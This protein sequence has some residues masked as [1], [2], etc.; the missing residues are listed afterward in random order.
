M[1]ERDK[2]LSKH[3]NEVRDVVAPSNV[4]DAALISREVGLLVDPPD[5]IQFNVA[6]GA[7]RIKMYIDRKQVEGFLNDFCSTDDTRSSLMKKWG[8]NPQLAHHIINSHPKAIASEVRRRVVKEQT[9]RERQQAWHASRN[10]REQQVI[11]LLTEIRDILRD[12][13]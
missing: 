13:E 12:K 11:D 4:P 2:T 8:I 9:S 5:V 6:R 3:V 7:K 1:P 10:A